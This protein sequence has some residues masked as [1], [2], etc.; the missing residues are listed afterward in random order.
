[1]GN[2]L[3][4]IGCRLRVVAPGRTISTASRVKSKQMMK[5]AGNCDGTNFD[6]RRKRKTSS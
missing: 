1:M 2:L 3:G 6:Y 5:I 4:E